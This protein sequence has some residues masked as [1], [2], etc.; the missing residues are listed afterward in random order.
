MELSIQDQ[1]LSTVEDWASC[2]QESDLDGSGW[3]EWRDDHA[4]YFFTSLLLVCTGLQVVYAHLVMSHSLWPHGLEPTRLFCP[5]DFPGKNTGVGFAISYSGGSLGPRDQTL[6]SWV[7]CIGR[8]IL[9]HCAIWEATGSIGQGWNVEA[10]KSDCLGSNPF[11]DTNKP[12]TK[13]SYLTSWIF[14]FLH[15]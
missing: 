12:A 7:S 15:L 2:P 8:R 6:V 4:L 3:R 13:A 5:W 9:H 1:H 14:L 11:F 10:L